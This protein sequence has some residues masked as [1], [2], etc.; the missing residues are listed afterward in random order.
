MQHL[1]FV[2]GTLRKG[3]SNHHF[4]EQS[5]YLGMCET[6]PEY[7]LYDLGAYLQLFLAE[8]VFKVK[9]IG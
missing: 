3:E 6:L 1:V 2:Y 7:A 4:I 8:A 5:E 9:F